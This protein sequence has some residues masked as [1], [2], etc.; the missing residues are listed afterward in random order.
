MKIINLSTQNTILNNFLSEIRDINYQRNRH[1]FRHN[2]IR[3]GELMAY[4]ISKELSYSPTIIQTPLA[5]T[6]MSLTDDKLVLAT[7]L[8]AGLPLVEGFLNVFD[9]ADSAFVSAYRYYKDA[10]QTEVGI[11]TEYLAA[12]EL[13]DKTLILVDP[14]LATG[15]SLELAYRALI[16]HGTPRKFI[17]AAVIAAQEG[18]DYLQKA[19]E[20]E[21]VTLYT[22]AID[23]TLND[24]KYIV[25]GLGDAG[26]LCFGEK[27]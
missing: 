27:L 6:T 4:E 12:P 17:I 2:I 20:N 5:P 22:A 19:F 14:M 25:P 11:K 18:I 15:G 23:P 24:K 16:A 21:D 1:L 7:V 13:T 26:D 10:K 8:R 9:H 3:I